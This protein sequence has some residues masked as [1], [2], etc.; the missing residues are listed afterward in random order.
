M[1]TSGSKRLIKLVLAGGVKWNGFSQ[2]EMNVVK[3]MRFDR[4]QVERDWHSRGFSCG[5]WVDPPGQ[6]WEDYVHS[7]DELLMVLE[8]ELE[9][10]LQ[11]RTFR[12]KQGEEVLISAHVR[13]TVRNVG[14]TTARWF[15]GYKGP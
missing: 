12:P 5:L 4:I 7:M 11:G 8:G 15:Y 10:E 14:G 3:L 9:L 1:Y 6:M 13:H 2:A